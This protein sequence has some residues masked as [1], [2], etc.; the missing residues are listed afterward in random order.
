LRVS[1]RQV[2]IAGGGIGALSAAL[3]C[4]RAGWDVRLYEQAAQFAE[5]GAGIQLGPNA[6]RLLQ[7]WGLGA[8]ME[9]VAA[10]P[11]KLQVRSATDGRELGCLPLGARCQA[12]YGAPYATVHRA[13]LHAI[14]HQA[15][16]SNSMQS[17][18]GA[19]Y[20]NLG[21]R[22]SGYVE[23]VDGVEL[24][25]PHGL[26][27]EGDALIGADGLWSSVRSQL[28]KD[29]PAKP[30]GHL[31][32]RTLVRQQ[33]LPMALRSQNVT[34]WLGPRLHVVSYPVQRGE[35]LNVVVI[36]HGQA[37]DPHD[38]DQAGVTRDVQAAL[39]GSCA[40]LVDL[41]NALPT[42]RLWVLCDRPPVSS[43]D[44]MAKGR[45]AL[46]GDAAHPMRPYMAQGA[47]MAIED[48][49]E[50]GRCLSCVEHRV[51]EVQ[52]ALRHY[53]LNRWERSARVQQRAER[54]GR[55]FHAT[56][57]MRWGR[58]L[59]LRLLGKRLLDVPWL[60]GPPSPARRQAY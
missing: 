49:A 23:S 22:V 21:V 15:L 41:G 35:A 40:S 28:L 4:S 14:L 16:D 30:T 43:P 39:A 52:Q 1:A 36:A 57:A 17:A 34:V 44:L 55:V 47:G 59:S 8:V 33:D 46:L 27:V 31:A 3:A 5:V 6:T 20:M 26:R 32:Y 13:D 7:A 19:G 10:F 58:D 45:V 37:G 18:S 11:D 29:G 53:A 42:W 54:N 25:W 48:A 12:R 38:W 2:L 24:T 60:Y 56:G 9:S 51:V 50:L